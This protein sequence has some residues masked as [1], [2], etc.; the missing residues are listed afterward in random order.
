[1]PSLSPQTLQV[2][3]TLVIVVVALLII[4]IRM[5]A[6]KRPTS[7]KKIL[8]P[9]LS[10]STGFLMF[11]FPIMRIRLLYALAALLVGLVFSIPLITS[12]KMFRGDDHH[13]YL[14]RSPTFAAVLLSL[15]V[16]RVLLHSY[17]EQ[18]ITVPQTGAVFFILAFG[19][20]LPW[21][22]AMLLTY[23]KLTRHEREFFK[24]LMEN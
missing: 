24:K 13:V 1:M 19:M 20:L 9:P 6:A 16:V 4:L 15:L 22:I 7:A 21:R 5:K 3:S 23:R 10:M 18:W 12:S 14:K 2:V 17:I 8:I 11:L